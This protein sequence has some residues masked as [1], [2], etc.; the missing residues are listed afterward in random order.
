MSWAE[1]V[2]EDLYAILSKN[3]AFDSLKDE[4]EDVYSLK[5]GEPFNG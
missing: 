1:T 2:I 3:P 5:D 4:K